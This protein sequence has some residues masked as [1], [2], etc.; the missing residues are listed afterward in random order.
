MRRQQGRLARHGQSRGALS[1]HPQTLRGGER[2]LHEEATAEQAVD[3]IGRGRRHR[4]AGRSRQRR[5]QRDRAGSS[6][7]QQSITQ[8]RRRAYGRELLRAYSIRGGDFGRRHR[9]RGRRVQVNVTVARPI[10]QVLSDRS[11]GCPSNFRDEP[12]SNSGG[13]SNWS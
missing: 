1:A 9:R 5:V 8:Q 3:D 2:A 7:A 11:G 6:G 4:R 13:S 10:L 12:S